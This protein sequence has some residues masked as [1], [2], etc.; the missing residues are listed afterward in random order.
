MLA[1]R[2]YFI[3][4]L[5]NAIKEALEKNKE[6]ALLFIDLD[7]FKDINDSL[8]HNVGDKLLQAVSNKLLKIVE[9]LGLV[10]RFGGDE[11]VVLIN[12]F[13]SDKK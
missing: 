6:V 8:G 11:F 12:K 10:G 2:R 9:E 13:D 5:D 4:E 7:Y 3:S 1:N